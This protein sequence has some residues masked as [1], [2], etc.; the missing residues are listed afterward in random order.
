M[1]KPEKFDMVHADTFTVERACSI[2]GKMFTTRKLTVRICSDECRERRKRVWYEHHGKTFR[3]TTRCREC[4]KD[5]ET[6]S[7]AKRICSDEC[8]KK[9]RQRRHNAWARKVYHERKAK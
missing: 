1:I 2:C 4:K 9:R 7:F 6:D 8:R 5:F 3:T